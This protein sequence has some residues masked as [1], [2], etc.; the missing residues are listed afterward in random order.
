MNP[1]YAVYRLLPEEERP[2]GG[3]KLLE[4]GLSRNPYNLK[5][6]LD[7]VASELE[8]SIA[9]ERNPAQCRQLASKIA[10]TGRYTKDAEQRRAWFES[11]RTCFE[12]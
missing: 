7:Q 8:Q 6:I 12:M 1:V 4:S 11:L 3:L 9:S 2:A 5:P 10:A